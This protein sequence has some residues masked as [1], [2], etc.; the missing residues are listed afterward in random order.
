MRN[1][2][3]KIKLRLKKGK[4]AVASMKMLNLNRQKLSKYYRPVDV[5]LIACILN[6]TGVKLLNC[7]PS[8]LLCMT[9]TSKLWPE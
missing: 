1:T 4:K 5:L 6:Y 3:I 2:A 9:N 8:P 7:N